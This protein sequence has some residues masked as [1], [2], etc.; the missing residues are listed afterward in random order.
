[1]LI[2]QES[3]ILKL[4]TRAAILKSFEEGPNLARKAEAYKRYQCLKDNTDAYVLKLLLKQFDNLTV[5][6]MQYAVTNISIARKII[7][8]LARVYANGVKRT[9]ADKPDDKEG[10]DAI[11][12]MAK[13]LKLNKQMKKLNRFFKLFKN[14]AIHLKP[15]LC[16]NGKYEIQAKVL[17][18]FLYDVVENPHNNE[19][20]L[21]WVLSS[22]HA[23][24]P[25]NYVLGDAAEARRGGGEVR[26]IEPNGV[27]PGIPVGHDAEKEQQE[28][29]WWSPSYHFTT[30]GKGN[31]KPTADGTDAGTSNPIMELPI[32]NLSED[33][34][35]CFWAKGGSDVADG[36]IKINAML[37]NVNHI[38]VTQGYGQLVIKGKGLP[39]SFK[40]GPNH[41]IILDQENKDDPDPSASFISANPPIADLLRTV[42]TAAALL[43]STNNLSTK[44]V[45][46]SL[47]STADFASGIAI[48][49]DMAESNEDVEEQCDFF[50]EKEPEIWRKIALWHALYKGKEILT[51]RFSEVVL[52]DNPIVAASFPPAQPIITEKEEL[53]AIQL[54]RDLGLNTDVEL[55]MRDDPS[56]TEETAKI[57]LE[58]IISDKLEQQMRQVYPIGI[59]SKGGFGLEKTPVAGTNVGKGMNGNQGNGNSGNGGPDNGNA[60][61]GPGGPQAP[62]G[63]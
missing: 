7:E 1:M 51:D 40:V 33:Q 55:L 23:P 38:A 45:R 19:E 17:P 42:E 2:S 35:D 62:V 47:Q 57:K 44:A 16:E 61:P 49:L 63:N 59:P 43:L 50:M 12:K 9:I 48:M 11:E 36:C 3:D 41:A 52:P 25:M 34:D 27:P 46:A 20:G 30:D 56:L 22:Y 8:K 53:E 37:T 5:N 24:E 29:I 32:V 28:F 18:P 31:L 6:E 39:K 4:E 26:Q 14:A 54:R 10:Q 60:G 21:V 15:V 58:K 13:L